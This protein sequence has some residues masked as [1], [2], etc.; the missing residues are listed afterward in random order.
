MSKVGKIARRT[1]LIG[2]AAVAGGVA[3]GVY[4]VRTPFDNPLENDLA[5]G[6]ATFN[7]W[8][9]IDS[10]KVTLIGPH[11]D[12]GQGIAHAQAALIA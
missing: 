2:A 8:V 4:K 12:K 10:E 3:F 1:F 6:A 5:D 11:G 7:P 9:I